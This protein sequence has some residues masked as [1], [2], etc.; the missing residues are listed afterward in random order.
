[1]PEGAAHPVLAIPIVTQHV[2]TAVV[3]Y[4]AHVNSTL[5]DPDEVVLL[6]ALAKAAAASHQ[7]VRIAMLMREKIEAEREKAAVEREAEARQVRIEE[8][9][10]RI[11]DLEASSAELRELVRVRLS[12]AHGSGR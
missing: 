9:Q 6:E 7:Q 8:Q 12:G 3:L 11:G 5:P 1:M 2:L 4:G 10:K